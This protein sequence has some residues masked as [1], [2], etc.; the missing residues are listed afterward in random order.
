MRK[1]AFGE[2]GILPKDF[3]PM[4]YTDYVLLQA[5]FINKRRYDQRIL[6]RMLVRLLEPYAKQGQKLDEYGIWPVPGDELLKAEDRQTTNQVSE[7]S[8]AIL[9]EFKEKERLQNSKGN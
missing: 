3:Y 8:L 9:A 4:Q 1:E 7:R 5:G 6:R 2:I